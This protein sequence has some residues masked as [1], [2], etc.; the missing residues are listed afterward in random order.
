MYL[1]KITSAREIHRDTLGG[2]KN[3]FFV[4]VKRCILRHILD[5]WLYLELGLLQVCVRLKRE[6]TSHS[7]S[8]IPACAYYQLLNLF[9]IL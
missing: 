3:N 8:W 7:N 5:Y 2:A 1:L 4:Y 6:G 9:V